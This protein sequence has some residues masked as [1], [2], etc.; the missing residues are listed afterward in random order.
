MTLYEQLGGAPA[1]SAALDR[2]YAK[3]KADPELSPFFAKTDFADL[4]R[5]AES[6]FAFAAGG[7]VEHHGPTLRQ[8]HRR[9]VRTGLNDRIFDRFV[10]TFES[11]LIE[12]QVPEEPKRQVMGMLWAARE[13]V[14]DR[15]ALAA[16]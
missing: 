12:L 10:N 1:V 3:V 7:S 6:F 13:E 4:K 11:V 15:P 16:G 14:L 5:R 2:F 9:F 8:A